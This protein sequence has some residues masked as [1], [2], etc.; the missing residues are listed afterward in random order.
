MKKALCFILV[1]MPVAVMALPLT[2]TAANGFTGNLV[3]ST[4]LVSSATYTLDLAQYNTPNIAAVV[5][6]SSGTMTAGSPGFYWQGSNDDS[7]YF[8]IN[9]SSITL[10]TGTVGNYIVGWD[11]SYITYRYLRLNFVGPATG[12]M[13]LKA[14]INARN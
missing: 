12:G 5:T 1:F 2:K 9:T 11:F 13:T 3:S 14:V 6:Y 8:N 4:T 7:S 10:S